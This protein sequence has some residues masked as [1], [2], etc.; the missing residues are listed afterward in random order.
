MSPGGRYATVVIP[1][2]NEERGL[3]RLLPSLT[4]GAV[5]TP[6]V[7]VICNGCTDGSATEATRHGPAVELVELVEASKAAALKAGGERVTDFPVA[8]VDADVDIDAASVAALAAALDEPGVLAVGPARLLDRV[9]VSLPA[10]WYYDVWERLPAV[11]SGLFGRG[12]IMLSEEGYRRVAALPEF[13]SD[14][15]AYS[16]AFHPSERQIVDAAVVRIWPARTWRALLLRRVR[17]VQGNR[18]LSDAGARSDAAVT[19]PRDLMAIAGRE[20]RLL[21][22]VA[23]FAVTALIARQRARRHKVEWTRDETSRAG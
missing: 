23:L 16:E 5:H 11:R 17:V 8:F 4:S 15:L 12:V 19:S 13:I 7:L 21:L 22:P 10:R 3:R 18:Q 6:R 14:D 2:H 1:A 20:P 9:G